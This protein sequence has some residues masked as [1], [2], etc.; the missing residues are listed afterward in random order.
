MNE[1]RHAELMK[2]FFSDE[3]STPPT[4]PFD[5]SA[6]NPFEDVHSWLMLSRIWFERFL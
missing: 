1:K 3:D 2:Q 6:P 4:P 5:P